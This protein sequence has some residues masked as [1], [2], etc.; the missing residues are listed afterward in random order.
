MTTAHSVLKVVLRQVIRYDLLLSLSVCNIA[1]DQTWR[2]QDRPIVEV[3]EEDL[4]VADVAEV[5]EAAEDVEL[6]VQEEAAAR[7]RRNGSP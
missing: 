5:V 3:S 2:T 7:M 1:F 6:A 4:V